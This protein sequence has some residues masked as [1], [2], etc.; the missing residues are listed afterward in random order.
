MTLAQMEAL[1][2]AKEPPKRTLTLIIPATG[3]APDDLRFQEE[4]A[5][6][7]AGI[8]PT[9]SAKVDV[10]LLPSG[11]VSFTCHRNPVWHEFIRSQK[12]LMRD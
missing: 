10:D 8:C 4:S 6:L 7:E 9:C 11:L 12:F 1:V 3:I 2:A 5:A